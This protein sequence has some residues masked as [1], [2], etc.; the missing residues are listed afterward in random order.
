LRHAPQQP[1]AARRVLADIDKFAQILMSP[2]QLTT[3]QPE[4][5]RG[6]LKRALCALLGM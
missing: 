4:Q 1:V 3:E 6:R 2:G 5:K